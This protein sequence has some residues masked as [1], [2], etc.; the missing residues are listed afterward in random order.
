MLDLSMSAN[1]AFILF[2]SSS[3]DCLLYLSLLHSLSLYLST[4][5]CLFLHC[6]SHNWP[7]V[8]PTHAQTQKHTQTHSLSFS[9]SLSLSQLPSYF[10][11]DFI[12]F[13][14]VTW[15][16]IVSRMLS[17]TA[18]GAWS[19]D[20]HF[21]LKSY[22]AKQLLKFRGCF[23]VWLKTIERNFLQLV[24]LFGRHAKEA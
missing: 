8:S 15:A 3:I 22:D 7:L 9:L 14:S 1:N 10:I 13:V 6:L 2:L 12:P 16:D 20:T 17:E 23:L 21:G 4:Y 5:L 11:F 18:R 19:H 24:L